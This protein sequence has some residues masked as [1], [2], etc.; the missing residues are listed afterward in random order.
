MGPGDLAA[1]QEIG[2][3]RLLFVFAGGAGSQIPVAPAYENR[4][5]FK[6]TALHSVE[7]RNPDAWAG[8]HGIVIGTGNTAHDTVEDM[9]SAGLASVTV[10]A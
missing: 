2:R 3:H 5:A 10:G 7:Y 9:L 1:R 8:K 4:G 6:G